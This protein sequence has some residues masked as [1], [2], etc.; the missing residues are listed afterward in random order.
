[1]SELGEFVS[2]N[3]MKR[4]DSLRR[5]NFRLFFDDFKTMTFSPIRLRNI[6]KSEQRQSRKSKLESRLPAKGLGRYPT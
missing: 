5:E 2:L 4:G 1:M 6:A 3:W